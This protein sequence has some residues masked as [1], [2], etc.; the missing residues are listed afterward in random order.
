MSKRQFV[1]I[2]TENGCIFPTALKF[3]SSTRVCGSLTTS[4]KG[5][6]SSL[7]YSSRLWS[8]MAKKLLNHSLCLVETNFL[9]QNFSSQLI[10]FILLSSH[11]QAK[12]LLITYVTKLQWFTGKPTIWSTLTRIFFIRFSQT[13]L[14]IH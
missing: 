8:N 4:A 14:I 13:H 12:G 9:I 5:E 6:C 10:R 7:S 11:L 1:E 2:S 3:T